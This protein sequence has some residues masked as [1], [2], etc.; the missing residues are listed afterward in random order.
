MKQR[1]DI[2]NPEILHSAH[3]HCCFAR[4]VPPEPGPPMRQLALKAE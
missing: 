4:I 1:C 2:A 3:M